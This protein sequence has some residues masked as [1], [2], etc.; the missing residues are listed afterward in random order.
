MRYLEFKNGDRVA[1]LGLGTWKSAPGEV[2]DAVRTAIKIGY[3]HID[4]AAVYGN[5]AEIGKAFAD[6]F[7]DGDVKRE[8]L[9]VTSKLW[10][11]A[12]K[13]DDVRPA[14]EQTLK[15]L[16]LDYLDLYLIHWP[17]AMK[18]GAGFPQSADDFLTLAEAPL[19]DTWQ[20]MEAAQADGLVRHIGVSNFNIATI[21]LIAQSAKVMPEM[22]QVEMHPF[23]PQHKLVNYCQSKGIHLTAYSPLGSSDRPRKQE[24][25]PSLM[26]HEVVKTIADAQGV[27]AAQVLLAWQVNRGVA[28]IPKSTNE[29]RLKQNLEAASIELSEDQ[30]KHLND[31][32]ESFRYIDGTIWT[33]EGSPY[34]LEDLWEF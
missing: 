1:S 23:L 13:K 2:Y 31:L 11:T 6:A 34:A 22:N 17:I 27:T 20:E 26:G 25:E 5:E 18:P 16:Q 33:I 9:W 28:V 14:L 30:M 24:N 32:N 7:K 12:H 8:E 3:R 21:E 19:E 4:C 29:G 10:N 15:D